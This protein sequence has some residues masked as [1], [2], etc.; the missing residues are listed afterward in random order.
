MERD[1]SPEQFRPD[2]VL[3]VV[4]LRASEEAVTDAVVW[5][6]DAH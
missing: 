1:N 3:Q 6:P 2:F 4:N 5:P